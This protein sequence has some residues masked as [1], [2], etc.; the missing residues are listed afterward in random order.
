[1]IE[2]RVVIGQVNIGQGNSI[3]RVRKKSVDMSV[4]K[5]KSLTSL[6][7]QWR[8]LGRPV[9]G[10]EKVVGHIRRPDKGIVRV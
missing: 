7:D 9:K 1:M 10:T 2:A 5:K 6:K 3:E 4:I 8:S